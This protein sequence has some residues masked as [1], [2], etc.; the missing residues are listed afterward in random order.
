MNI[1]IV[2]I[3]RRS[4]A[5]KHA[6]AENLL[7]HY[8]D[9]IGQF[10]SCEIENYPSE[11]KFRSA[12]RK[13]YS[14]GRTARRLDRYDRL[15]LLD[16]GGKTFSTEQFAN[17]LRDQ[18]DRGLGSLTFAV[19]PADGWS[20]EFR[21]EAGMLLSL[22]PMTLPHELAAVVLAEQMYRGFTIL[23]GHPYHSGHG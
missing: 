15:V 19:G 16:P 18:G 10:C 5:R 12:L 11:E 8:C 23:E 13:T 1:R 14:R 2:T 4:T 20:E 9:R 7:S 22:G 21:R 3:G 17:W 6:S